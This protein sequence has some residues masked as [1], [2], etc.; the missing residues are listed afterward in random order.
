[1]NCL[2]CGKALK[3]DGNYYP[4]L[5]TKAHLDC[6]FEFIKKKRSLLKMIDSDIV[7]NEKEVFTT[8]DYCDTEI[9]IGEY[10]YNIHHEEICENC[11]Y[12]WS[13]NYKKVA[14]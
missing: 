6:L 1:M 9:Y 10:Y 7:Q 14:E 2:Y 3:N 8:C 4:L 5:D 13:F 12:E 11:L